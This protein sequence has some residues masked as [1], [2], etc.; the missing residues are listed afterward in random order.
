MVSSSGGDC[1]RDAG[2]EIT[3]EQTVK[4]QQANSNKEEAAVAAAPSDP[5]KVQQEERPEKEARKEKRSEK[6]VRKRKPAVAATSQS[7]TVIDEPARL[8][9][10]AQPMDCAR[11]G[12]HRAPQSNGRAAGPAQENKER[13]RAPQSQHRG[14]HL[15]E[16]HQSEV[17]STWSFSRG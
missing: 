1:D 9:T 2:A 3:A 6:E 16:T 17:S 5:Q 11:V 13:G 7:E 15:W 8:G 4:K 12:V 10:D 14:H